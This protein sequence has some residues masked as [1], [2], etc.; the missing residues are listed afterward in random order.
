[1]YPRYFRDWKTLAVWAFLGLAPVWYWSRLFTGPG[2]LAPSDLY[3][4]FLPVFLSP[5]L[6]WSSSEFAGLPAAAD[7]QSAVQSIVDEIASALN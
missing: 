7:P 4:Q 6:K 2:V 1:M 3:E 5:I